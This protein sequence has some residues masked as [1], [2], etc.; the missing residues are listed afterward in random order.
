MKR[1]E[2]TKEE[3]LQKLNEELEKAL[4]EAE[5]DCKQYRFM[6]IGFKQAPDS[7]GC[8]WP[9]AKCDRGGGIAYGETRSMIDGIVRK[10][11]DEARK[12]YNLK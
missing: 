1:E 9:D 5:I 7:E 10:I 4:K 6:S 12:K 8:N 11:V 2:K 3:L